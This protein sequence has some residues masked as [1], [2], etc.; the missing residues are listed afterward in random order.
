MV[1]DLQQQNNKQSP[2]QDQLFQNALQ[3]A[4]QADIR[5]QIARNKV[6]DM[7]ILVTKSL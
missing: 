1:N 4:S 3:Q 5:K 6:N 7:G 2:S